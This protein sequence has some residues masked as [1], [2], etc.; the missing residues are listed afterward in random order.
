MNWI[1][2]LKRV[3]IKNLLLNSFPVLLVLIT[4]QG[5]CSYVKLHDATDKLRSSDITDKF[6]LTNEMGIWK[7]ANY[8]SSFGTRYALGSNVEIGFEGAG[9]ATQVSTVASGT[10]LRIIEIINIRCPIGT[11]HGSIVLILN[12]DN[13]FE[14]G[15]IAALRLGSE[16]AY[17][18]DELFE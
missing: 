15:D 1:N 13:E 8:P 3:Q 7:K 4:L 16:K 14:N 18:Y 17:L 12:I 2:C 11:P 9:N 6:V 5:C 10:R